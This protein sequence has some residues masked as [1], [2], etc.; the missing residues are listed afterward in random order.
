MAVAKTEELITSPAMRDYIET[1]STEDVEK[2]RTEWH[3]RFTHP[4]KF[5]DVIGA[6]IIYIL[7]IRLERISI[8]R[9]RLD[10]ELTGNRRGL[11]VTRGNF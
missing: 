4:V 1:M 3:G 2:Y 7:G 11:S 10:S 9:I 6:L 8:I 5:N